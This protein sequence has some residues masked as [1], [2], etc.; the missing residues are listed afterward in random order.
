MEDTEDKSYV[1]FNNGS[2]EQVV[3]A[4]QLPV[5][6]DVIT[7]KDK[8]VYEKAGYGRKG[9]LGKNPAILIIDVT[10]G[11][12]GDKPEPILQSIERFPNS[13]GEDGWNAVQRTVELLDLGRRK[14]VPVFYTAGVPKIDNVIAGKWAFKHP[15]TM[16]EMNQ[17]SNT[18]DAIPPEIA[19]QKGDIVITKLKPS[20]FFGTPLVSHLVSLGIDTILATGCT[21][22]GCVRASVIDAFSYNYS[23][24]IVEECT[25]DRGEVPHK[26]NLFDMNQKY[27]DVV[28][29]SAAKEYLSSFPD[30]GHS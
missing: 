16:E 22:S 18:P 10:I 11:F 2:C 20:A 4:N 29:L 27:A 26:V 17:A 21:T 9:G 30:G 13:C 28:S 5:W 23:V 8:Q 14:H 6:D 19:P 3:E 25:F 12:V 24:G 15:R 1:R 7:E